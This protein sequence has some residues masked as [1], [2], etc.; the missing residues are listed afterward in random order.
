MSNTA[1]VTPYVAD[2]ASA[3]SDY[4]EATEADMAAS[5][6][7]LTALRAERLACCRLNIMPDGAS[8]LLHAAR[9]RG[10]VDVAAG[11]PA[12]SAARR[13]E[14]SNAAGQRIWLESGGE[15]V[16]L[17]GS[18]SAKAEL[19]AIVRQRTMNAAMRHLQTL[20]AM[21][22]A[23][24]TLGNGTVEL[25]VKEAQ[26]GQTDGQATV[27][28]LID[29]KGDIK[30][31]IDGLRGSRCE[32]LLNATAKAMGGKVGNKKIKPSYY[33]SDAVAP[34]RIRVKG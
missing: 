15:R 25:V 6:S 11:A 16:S 18:Q 29:A 32:V 34:T 31:D 12:A 23:M 13:V 5:A 9:E 27:T 14:L 28:A 22:V 8:S 19:E 10:F 20:S 7:H 26:H 21:P 17:V 2:A 33:S 4:L 30:L 1:E 24:R 3:L